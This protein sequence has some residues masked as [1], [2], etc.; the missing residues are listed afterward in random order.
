M[1]HKFGPITKVEKR[2]TFALVQ[3]DAV[4][5]AMAALKELNGVKVGCSCELDCICGGYLVMIGAAP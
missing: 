4:E 2:S 1:F 5:D 3:F